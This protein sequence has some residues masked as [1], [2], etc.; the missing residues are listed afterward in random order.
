MIYINF[1]GS[2][3]EH[4]NTDTLFTETASFKKNR[5]TAYVKSPSMCKKFYSP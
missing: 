2:E 5:K 1:I 3:Y 4:L